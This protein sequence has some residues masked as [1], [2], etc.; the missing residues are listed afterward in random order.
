MFKIKKD[1]GLAPVF[2]VA[3]LMLCAVVVSYITYRV[4]LNVSGYAVNGTYDA[5]ETLTGNKIPHKNNPGDI[6]GGIG[7]IGDV[8]VSSGSSSDDYEEKIPDAGS[9]NISIEFNDTELDWGYQFKDSDYDTYL[10]YA[11]NEDC[12]AM[13]YEQF[14]MDNAKHSEFRYT[15][16]NGGTIV[17]ED[18]EP[19]EIYCIQDGFHWNDV[20]LTD[21]IRWQYDEEYDCHMA[22][23]YIETSFNLKEN[24]RVYSFYLETYNIASDEEEWQYCSFFSTE[25][26]STLDDFKKYIYVGLSEDYSTYT[27]KNNEIANVSRLGFYIDDNGNYL[28]G[29][30]AEMQDYT[31]K[32]VAGYG[33][34]NK[35]FGE[36]VVEVQPNE[37]YQAADG[38]ITTELPTTPQTGD[39]YYYGDYE[40]HYNST[41][42]QYY[43]FFWQEENLNGWSVRVRD[44]SKT[45]YGEILREIAGKP[46]VNLD[47][48]FYE[49]TNMVKA[50]VLP[51]VE[52]LYFTFAYC[53]SLTEA[54][55]I[56][57]TV[58]DMSCTFESC[59]SLTR[60]P[61]IHSSVQ[62]M[63]STYTNCNNLI[64]VPEFP[65]DSQLIELRSAFAGCSSLTSIPEIPITVIDMAGAF[66]NCNS[67]ERAPV[68]HENVIY[69]D[70]TFTNCTS[71][72]GDIEINIVE[73]FNYYNYEQCFKGT[74]KPIRITGTTPYKD[75]FASTAN[76]GN[77]TY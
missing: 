7:G 17:I 23:I 68:I 69:I 58:V 8:P 14:L 37:Y 31:F 12:S 10:Y 29:S 56:P 35:R 46:V 51:K 38:E 73:C 22:H 76:N 39:I 41:I 40:Y 1:K 61:A 43:G 16:K 13:T 52:E 18:R 55:I 6:A 28:S 49:C 20:D 50:P 59:K 71:L 2:V 4:S 24:E 21:V 57:E 66:A 34:E 67:L 33:N 74:V 27:F 44:T 70:N 72:T 77:V 36:L 60:A 42:Y 53:E 26:L 45:S 3:I 25:E 30:P 64:Y 32:I 65:L 5:Y 54:P 48:T 63:Y 75:L 47:Y 19:S 15:N 9:Y 11:Y 62:R